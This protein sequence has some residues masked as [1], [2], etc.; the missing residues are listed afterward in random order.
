MKIELSERQMQAIKLSLHLAARWEESVLD[1]LRTQLEDRNGRMIYVVP[2]EF[3]AE[4]KISIERMRYFRS[5]IN[6]LNMKGKK[7]GATNAI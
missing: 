4:E 6:S 3:E 2:K 5:L 1:S 7:K